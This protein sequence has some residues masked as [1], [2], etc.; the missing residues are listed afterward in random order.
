M[1]LSNRLTFWAVEGFRVDSHVNGHRPATGCLEWENLFG[2]EPEHGFCF[3][4][5]EDIGIVLAD[6]FVCADDPGAAHFEMAEESH[7]DAPTDVRHPR[8]ALDT[9]PAAE[10]AAVQE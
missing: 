4:G 7:G 3:E 6:E 8:D 9:W 1:L 10:G 5:T 2:S